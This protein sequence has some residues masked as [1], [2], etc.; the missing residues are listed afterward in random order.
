M[1][2]DVKVDYA[3]L[4]G[5]SFFKVSQQH[6]EYLTNRLNTIKISERNT[7]GNAAIY[8]LIGHKRILTQSVEMN[9]DSERNLFNLYTK[10][11]AMMHALGVK[12]EQIDESLKNAI[13]QEG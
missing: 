2:K 10:T 5:D 7:S 1:V 9:S 6:M 8:G 11:E 13:E 4:Q 3:A 12:F